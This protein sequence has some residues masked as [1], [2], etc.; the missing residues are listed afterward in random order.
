MTSYNSLDLVGLVEALLQP[1]VQPGPFLV[2]GDPT[3]SIAKQL[4][5][6][7]LATVAVLADSA[8]KLA[9]DRVVCETGDVGLDDI[10]ERDVHQIAVGRFGRVG[11]PLCEIE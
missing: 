5:E 7:R 8:P 4:H 10:G 11:K 3:D 1:L 2:I 9:E 6:L